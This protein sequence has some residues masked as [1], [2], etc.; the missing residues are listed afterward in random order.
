M[1]PTSFSNLFILASDASSAVFLRCSYSVMLV[2]TVFKIM[3][4]VIALTA[5]AGL[6]KIG[7][8]AWAVVAVLFVLSDGGKFGGN[9]VASK[10]YKISSMG[11]CDF[12]T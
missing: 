11:R 6:V 12:Q 10:E 7:P 1:A 3:S 4:S 2:R 5:V 9:V 8:V